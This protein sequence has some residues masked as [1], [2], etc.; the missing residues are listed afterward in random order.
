[1]IEKYDKLIY[2]LI[3]TDLS[4]PITRN[5]NTTHMYLCRHQESINIMQ[6]MLKVKR[7]YGY[8]ANKIPLMKTKVMFTKSIGYHGKQDELRK[9]K[10]RKH[11]KIREPLG[12]PL[13]THFLFFPL[14]YT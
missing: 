8:L 2:H 11:E 3:E 10:E 1:M 5:S 6:T 4:M 13:S 9:N 7:N 12:S 14:F